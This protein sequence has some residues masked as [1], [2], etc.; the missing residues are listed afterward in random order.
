[1]AK[2]NKLVFP[3]IGILAF[4]VGG[5]AAKWVL[6]GMDKGEKAQVT[7]SVREM[8]DQINANSPQRIDDIT[9]MT[10]A[11]ADGMNLVYDYVIAG[12]R[13][14]YPDSFGTE[15]SASVSRAVCA[16][17]GM[18]KY[19]NEGVVYTFRYND[20]KGD[21]IVSFSVDAATCESQTQAAP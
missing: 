11:T 21:G 9:T 15:I 5:A 14:D 12:A 18:G 8:A 1:M 19:I 6:V 2:L 20:S 16:D 13:T 4:A 10:R 3:V 17:A 7:Q